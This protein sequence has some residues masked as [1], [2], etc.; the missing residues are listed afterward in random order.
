MMTPE[1]R[2]TLLIAKAFTVTLAGFTI[3]GLFL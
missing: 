2:Q 1:Q 3:Y